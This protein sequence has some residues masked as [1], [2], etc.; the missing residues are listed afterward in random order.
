MVTQKV[1]WLQTYLKY[2]PYG[3]ENQFKIEIVMKTVQNRKEI[4]RS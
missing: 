3:F 2:T 1:L 4:Q